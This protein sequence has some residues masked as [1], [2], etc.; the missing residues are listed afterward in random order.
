MRPVSLQNRY[1]DQRGRP[2]FTAGSDPC[3]HVVSVRPSVPNFKYPAKQNNFQV[4]IV[5]ATGGTVGLV[6][7]I[8]DSTHVL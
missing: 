2:T 4:R 7:W 1:I 6:E 8:I 5:I 3:S